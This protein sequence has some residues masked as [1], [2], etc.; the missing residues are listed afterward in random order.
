[1]NRA[2]A[3]I[4]RQTSPWGRPWP[5]HPSIATSLTGWMG[6]TVLSC[7]SPETQQK[8][9]NAQGHVITCKLH[10]TN[11]SDTCYIHHSHMTISAYHD[12]CLFLVNPL[13]LLITIEYSALGLCH[14]FPETDWQ[15]I[16]S[17]SR[18]R[19]LVWA[20]CQPVC[21]AIPRRTFPLNVSKSYMVGHRVMLQHTSWTWEEHIPRSCSI[22]AWNPAQHKVYTRENLGS[23]SKSC[24]F[25]ISLLDAQVSHR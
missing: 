2:C 4:T 21:F 7:H 3:H 12:I 17:V 19:V 13:C 8:S 14:L 5:R 6:S 11:I 20:V 22:P 15:R 16:H 10:M 24:H 23:Q 25:P 1:M 18:S 9:W